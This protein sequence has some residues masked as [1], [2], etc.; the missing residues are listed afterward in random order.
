MLINEGF[1]QTAYSLPP[2]WDGDLPLKALIR[3][4][5]PAEIYREVDQECKGFQKRLAGRRL[6]F[7]ST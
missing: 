4:T 6:S 7:C 1:Q 3:R 5:L 2:A